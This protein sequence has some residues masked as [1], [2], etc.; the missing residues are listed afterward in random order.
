MRIYSPYKNN[1]VLKNYKIYIRYINENIF[2][3]TNKKIKGDDYN[4]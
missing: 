4:G 3:K 1:K 2:Q